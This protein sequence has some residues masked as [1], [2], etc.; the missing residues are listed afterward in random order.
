MNGILK[1]LK[2]LWTRSEIK[3]TPD[4]QIINNLKI[5]NHQLTAEVDSLRTENMRLHHLNFD[6]KK[7]FKPTGLPTL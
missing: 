3:R 4:Q 5:R 6:L 7:L 1:K 2:K